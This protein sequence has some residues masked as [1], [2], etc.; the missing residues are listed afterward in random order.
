MSGLSRREFLEACGK[1][2]ALVLLPGGI[3]FEAEPTGLLAE[4]CEFVLE[5]S[6][7]PPA[8]ARTSC[9]CG[10]AEDHDSLAG[11]L[12]A[13]YAHQCARCGSPDEEITVVVTTA[14]YPPTTLAVRAV[15]ERT[16]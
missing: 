16:A 7:P 12:Q 8:A 1:G 6:D 2:A 4:D 11:A 5:L 13:I 9:E 3:E 14:H 10:W 15:E